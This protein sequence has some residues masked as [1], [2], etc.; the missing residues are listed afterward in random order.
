MYSGAGGIKPTRSGSDV[1]QVAFGVVDVG[2]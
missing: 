2:A 1:P